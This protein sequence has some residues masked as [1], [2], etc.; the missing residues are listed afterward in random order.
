[1]LL[2]L[3]LV[4]FSLLL[5]S[6]IVSAEEDPIRLKVEKRYEQFQ[7]SDWF[8][9]SGLKSILTPLMK[10]INQEHILEDEQQFYHAADLYDAGQK[11]LAFY[12]KIGRAHV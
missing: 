12:Y 3:L 4:P 6:V 1:M 9:D 11:Q 8:T 10:V 5:S 7:V 2:R